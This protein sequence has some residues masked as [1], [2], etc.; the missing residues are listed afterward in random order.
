M[1]T[2]VFSIRPLLI[3]IF[4]FGACTLPLELDHPSSGVS[5][6]KTGIQQEQRNLGRFQLTLEVKSKISPN[7][8]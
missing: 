1:N 7:G 5:M 4:L 8:L 2:K 6:Q 3:F